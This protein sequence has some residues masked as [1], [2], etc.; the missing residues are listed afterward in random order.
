[1]P[2]ADPD[3]GRRFIWLISGFLLVSVA[4]GG[5]FLVAYLTLPTSTETN[6]FMY[7]GMTL[8]CIP[9]CFW[10][11]TCVYRCIA[12]VTGMRIV[13]GDIDASTAASSR[14]FGAGAAGGM[15]RSASN[16]NGNNNMADLSRDD[17]EDAGGDGGRGRGMST[18]SHE[19]EMPLAKSM[20]S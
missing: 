15:S 6:T 17:D 3:A 9:W 20:A 14:K 1:M 4:V 12:H 7:V 10:I 5:G 19:S 2:V 8:V 18:A 11:L 13:C 16:R